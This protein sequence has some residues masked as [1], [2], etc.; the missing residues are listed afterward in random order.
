[1]LRKSL[2]LFAIVGF[3]LAVGWPITP[4]QAHC[5]KLHSDPDHPHCRNDGTGPAGGSTYDVTMMGDLNF[6]A[7]SYEGLD[8]GG[9]SKPVNL[10]FQPIEIGLVAF[11]EDEAVH[12]GREIDEIISCFGDA[13]LMGNT[14]AITISQEKGG[15]ASL[16]YWFTGRGADGTTSGADGTPIRYLLEMRD[17]EFVGEWRPSLSEPTV[18][19][20]VSWE[21]SIDGNKNHKIACTGSG[22]FYSVTVEVTNTTGVE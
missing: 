14:I 22:S 3:V 8:G 16:N 6:D 10:D 20:F 12:F 11:F 2:I 18:A 17:A 15:K 13:P 21:M 4:V 9:K 7:L 19:T 5:K 1:M